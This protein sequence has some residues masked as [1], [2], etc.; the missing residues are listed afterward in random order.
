MKFIRQISY[1]A[2]IF[3]LSSCISRGD[4][5]SPL[6]TI[7]SPPNGSVQN[8]QRPIVTGYAMDDE[9]I[10][11][12]IVNGQDILLSDLLVNERGK[13]LINFAFEPQNQGEGSFAANIEVVDI[14]GRSSIFPYELLIDQ[15]PPTVDLIEVTALGG[16]RLRVHGIARDNDFVKSITI[17]G[18][19]I[20][21]RASKEYQFKADVDFSSDM[22][23]VVKDNAG[24][25]TSVPLNP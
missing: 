19:S 9:G 25:E 10:V 23:L 8:V 3:T 6:I 13:K 1:I 4:S 16:N 17:A 22:T 7:V 24:N 21:F 5:I 2:L 12:I 18:T 15:T 20:L 14:N 11:S